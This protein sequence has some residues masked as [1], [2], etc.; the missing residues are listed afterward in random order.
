MA[1]TITRTGYNPIGATRPLRGGFGADIVMTMGEFAFGT[2]YTTAGM[3]LTPD[4]MGLQDCLFCILTV[5]PS[6]GSAAVGYGV[7]LGEARYDYDTQK[8][9][10]FQCSAGA[11]AGSTY[12]REMTHGATLTGWTIRF[13]AFG[14]KLA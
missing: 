6:A 9:M 12:Q 10:V 4:N 8:V 5:E 13:V 11:D 3:S 14:H 1:L 7:S 2:V